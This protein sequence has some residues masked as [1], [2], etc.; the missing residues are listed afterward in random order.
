MNIEIRPIPIYAW[1][2]GVTLVDSAMR[3]LAD[4]SDYEHAF[5]MVTATSF[6]LVEQ[7]PKGE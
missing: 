2:Y 5:G 4:Q 1:E 6:E 3:P 7:S